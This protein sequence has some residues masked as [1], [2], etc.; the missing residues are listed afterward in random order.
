M[1]LAASTVV[2]I[3]QALGLTPGL[4]DKPLSLSWR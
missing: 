2:P 4:A 3:K 1:F